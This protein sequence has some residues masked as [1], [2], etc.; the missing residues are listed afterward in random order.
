M[1]PQRK[2]PPTPSINFRE[3]TGRIDK[4]FEVLTPLFGGGVH[5][6]PERTHQKLCDRRTPVRGASVRG[7]L[8]FW[9]RATKGCLFES[10]AAMLAR[11]TEI[12]GNASHPGA[13]G[14]WIARQPELGKEEPVYRTTQGGNGNYQPRAIDTAIG[15][16]AFSLQ[17]LSQHLKSN[18][19]SLR[20]GGK[21]RY[22]TGK[23]LLSLTFPEAM[24]GDVEAAVEAWTAFGGIGGRTRRG[25][26]A[27]GAAGV[28]PDALKALKK[29]A[30]S[31]ER[32]LSKVP[33]LHGA[34]VEVLAEDDSSAL[35]A[36]R[37]G[38]SKLQQLRQGSGL[39]RNPGREN[40]NKPGRSRWPEPELIR[41]L[42]N[43]SDPQHRDRF[44]NVDKTPRWVFGMPIVF[45]FQSKTD[46]GETELRPRDYERMASPLIIRPFKKPNGRYGCLA[47]AL[48]I[49]D[50]QVPLKLAKAPGDPRVDGQITASEVSRIRPLGGAMSAIS[51]FLDSFR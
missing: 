14:L 36:L 40:P 37:R 10:Q 45:H 24:R 13:V 16:G 46:P 29:W 15:Y 6:D 43:K 30:R 41:K 44:V 8:R 17:P 51:A 1:T 5:V 39:G 23:P 50:M 42:T 25:F 21:L 32:T 47:V 4:E 11:E 20:E 12:W 18:D 48:Q 33:S 27:V 38:L 2:T 34:R 3:A 49:P 9:W 28:E 7:Q 31:Q 26:G 19:A 35:D 22:L